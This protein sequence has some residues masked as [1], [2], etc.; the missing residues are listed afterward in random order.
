MEYLGEN[1]DNQ[2]KVSVVTPSYA[3]KMVSDNNSHSPV[4][5]PVM[6]HSAQ[7]LKLNTTLSSAS[8]GG[9]NKILKEHNTPSCK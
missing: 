4:S 2:E 7:Q 6:E 1:I 9:Y 8:S 3:M 5:T